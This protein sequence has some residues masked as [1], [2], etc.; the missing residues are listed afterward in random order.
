VNQNYFKPLSIQSSAAQNANILLSAASCLTFAF[1]IGAAV[2]ADNV[3]VEASR[4]GTAVAIN[5]RATVKAPYELIWATL[6]DY[7]H[8]AEFIPG[9]TAS[10]VLER[11]GN[12]AVVEQTG[13]ARFLVFNYSIHAV[14]ESREEVPTFIGIHAVS[15][16]LKRLDGG[17]RLDKVEGAQDEF[18]LRWSG[19]IEPALSIPLFITVPIMRANLTDQFRGMVFEIERRDALRRANIKER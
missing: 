17:Y 11:R 18:V 19:F 10:R 9:M 3:V 8:L 2:A 13:Q 5:A 7:D 6:T 15:G 16:N 14:V 1:S 12:T 4:D